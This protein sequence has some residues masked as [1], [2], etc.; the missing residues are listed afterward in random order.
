MFQGSGFLAPPPP[1][2]GS[3]SD[4]PPWPGPWTQALG[5]VSDEPGRGC[6]PNPARPKGPAHG[7]WGQLIMSPALGRLIRAQA[8]PLS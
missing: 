8:L 4:L 6:E 1:R 3:P 5:A 7:P 2:G